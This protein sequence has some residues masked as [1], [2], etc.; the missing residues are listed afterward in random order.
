VIVAGKPQPS[1]IPTF[2]ANRT[3]SLTGDIMADPLWANFTQETAPSFQVWEMR[4]G[5]PA[6]APFYTSRAI[7]PPAA[8]TQSLKILA[9]GDFNGSG[10]ASPLILDSTQNALEIWTEPLNPLFESDITN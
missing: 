1:P 6:A 4:Q 7:I 10:Y 9:S 8:F 2:Y 3:M 5:P